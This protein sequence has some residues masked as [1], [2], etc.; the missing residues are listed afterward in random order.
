MIPKINKYDFYLYR[1]FSNG[2]NYLN[3]IQ[4][5]AHSSEFLNE[6]IL[7]PEEKEKL[8]KR[9]ELCKILFEDEWESRNGKIQFFFDFNKESAIKYYHN[10][11]QLAKELQFQSEI[12][13]LEKTLD[14]YIKN[15]IKIKRLQENQDD[16]D[17][18]DEIQSLNRE[19]EYPYSD[20]LN[21]LAIDFSINPDSFCRDMNGNSIDPNFTGKLKHYE[22]DTIKYEYSVQKGQIFGE[23]MEYDNDGNKEELSF[24]EGYFDKEIIKSWFKNGQIEF[25]QLSNSGYRYWYDNGQKKMENI[26]NIIKKWDKYVEEIL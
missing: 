23:F 12:P 8:S 25:E 9:I 18:W 2:D 15:E 20:L 22:G 5:V 1:D 11:I 26:N 16:D 10:L 7:T 6:V 21:K 24:K 17:A 19:Y 14:F 3:L 4:L 13:N